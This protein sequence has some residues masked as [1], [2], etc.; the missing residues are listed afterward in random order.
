MSGADRGAAPRGDRADRIDL[1]RAHDPID[2]LA[3]THFRERAVLGLLDRLAEAERPNAAEAAE[4]LAHVVHETPAHHRDE[5]D[6]LFPLLRRRAEPEDE[7]GPL[8]DRLSAEHE[9]AAAHARTL[10][11]VLARLAAGGA[12]PDDGERAA[13]RAYARAERRHLILENAVALPLA[14]ARL[15]ASDRRDVLRRMAALRGLSQT[16]LAEPNL[17][18]PEAA[19]DG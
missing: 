16:D 13:L 17:A 15:T 10:A 18:E 8:L 5:D 11:P 6:G 3:E 4:A 7:I 9:A 12:G 14:R 2:V 1:R 19:P